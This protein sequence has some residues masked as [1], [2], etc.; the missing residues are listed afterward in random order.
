MGHGGNHSVCSCACGVF[1]RLSVYLSFCLDLSLFLLLF[2]F[3][4]GLLGFGHW[5]CCSRRC[6]LR[7][8][9]NFMW[10]L[11][12]LISVGIEFHALVLRSVVC[13]IE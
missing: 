4:F 7:V 13:D 11:M 6:R 2:C 10:L 5:D 12:F 8:C 9:L 3:C 1:V